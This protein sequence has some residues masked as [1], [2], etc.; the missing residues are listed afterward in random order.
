[1]KKKV[2]ETA[3]SIMSRIFSHGQLTRV[4]VG[5]KVEEK[6]KEKKKSVRSVRTGARGQLVEKGKEEQWKRD[7]RSNP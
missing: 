1:M 3:T 7:C 4:L 2:L 5:L 6:T